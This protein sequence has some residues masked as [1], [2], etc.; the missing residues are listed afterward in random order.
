MSFCCGA[1]MIGTK[2]T[3]KH[4]RTQ[5]NNVPIV[6][7]PVCHRVE[8]HY[9]VEQEYELLAEF[10]HDDG[11]TEIDFIQYIEE[12]TELEL[13]ENCVN[14]DEEDPLQVVKYQ[15]DMAL[16]LLAIAKG[17]HDEEWI[18][19]LK[20]RLTMLS[21]RRSKLTKRKSTRGSR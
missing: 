9:L 12:N 5:I 4:F 18:E 1:S 11:A 6:F 19:Q 15:I 13:F 2:G 8:V 14:H 20:K 10:A 3:L 16:D 17:L 21:S 7:C